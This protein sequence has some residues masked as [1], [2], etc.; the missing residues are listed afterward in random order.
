MSTANLG[1]EDRVLHY[2]A[3]KRGKPGGNEAFFA[4]VD[5]EKERQENDKE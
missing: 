3:G 5:V 1:W 4:V 2:C